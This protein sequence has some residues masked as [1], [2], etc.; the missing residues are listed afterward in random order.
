[1]LNSLRIIDAASLLFQSSRMRRHLII[2]T[3]FTTLETRAAIDISNNAVIVLFESSYDTAPFHLFGD[4][5]ASYFSLNWPSYTNH[6]R[7][8]SRG[9]AGWQDANETRLERLGLDRK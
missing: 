4:Y 2:L 9:G 8:A 7:S 3:L 5:L 1:M 6:W